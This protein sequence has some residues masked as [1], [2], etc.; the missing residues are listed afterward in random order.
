FSFFSLFFA[1]RYL[2]SFPTRRS[3]DLSDLRHAWR[4]CWSGIS[5]VSALQRTA[6]DSSDD[7]SGVFRANSVL[8]ATPEKRAVAHQRS[9]RRFGDRKST[10]L[11]SSH[12]IISYA[13]FFLKK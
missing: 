11:N 5:T 3:S 10:R 8:S 6:S 2:L 13:V 7:G 9:Q 12:Q 1:L 4:R